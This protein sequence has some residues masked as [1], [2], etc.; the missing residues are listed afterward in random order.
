MRSIDFSFAIKQAI[1]V[2]HMNSAKFIDFTMLYTID[3]YAR[4]LIS[5]C[6]VV[7]PFRLVML[8]SRLR[9]TRVI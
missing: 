1:T 4:I 5:A 8:L 2:D 3:K 9:Q 6:A 7:Y